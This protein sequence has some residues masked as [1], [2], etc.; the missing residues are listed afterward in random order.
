MTDDLLQ[1]SC[2][3][4]LAAYL[5]DLGKFAERSGAFDDD[6]RL[7]AHLTMYCPYREEQGRGWF[8]HRH[9]AHTA[10]AFDLLERHLPDLL[11][12][13]VSPFIG[14]VH[15]TDPGT[16]EPT[17]SLVNAAAAHH[18]PSTFLQWVIATADRIASGFEREEFEQYNL[19]KDETRDGL[20]NFT[21][22]QVTL[23]EQVRLAPDAKRPEALKWRYPLV[24]L[25]PRGI[26]P[27]AAT[28]CESRDRAAAKLEYR[29]LWD[30]F[31]RALEAIPRS[32]RGNFALW[33]D[34]FDSLWLTYTHAIPAATAFNIKP[35]VSLYD[36]S[37]TTAAL[38]VA[39]WRW[40]VA[41]GRTDA[42][43]TTA[44]RTRT[45]YSE[46]KFLLV[47]G[48][49]FGIQ[50]FVFAAGGE[51]RK[52]AAKLLRGRSF[53]VSLFTEI[54]AL[55]ILDELSLP[56]TSQVLNA[57]GK[58]LLVAPNTQ[59]VR[60]A[61][62]GVKAKFDRW[63]L[64]NSFGVAGLGLAWTPAACRDFLRGGQG[65]SS[66]YQDLMNRLAQSLEIA[67]YRRFGLATTGARIFETGY[68]LGV[69]EYNGRLPA[70]RPR[71]P[72]G[73]P[74]S[75]ALSRDQI[76]IGEALLRFDR[77]MVVDE[78]RDAAALRTD[79]RTEALESSYFG[80]R[81]AFT[82]SGE[83]SGAFGQL[84]STGA[85]R[86]CWDFAAADPKRGEGH[87]PLWSGYA[88]RF[89]SG[90][91]PQVDADDLG[92]LFGRYAGLE[93]DAKAP[94]GSVKPF[95]MLACEDRRP[96]PDGAGWLGVAALGV[97]KG[98]IDNLGNLFRVGLGSPTF[99]K[100]AAL[101]RQVNG[102]FAIY[103]PWLLGREFRSVYTVFAGGDDF[104]LVGPWRT[105]QRVAYRLREDF[106]RYVAGNQDV[107][108]SAGIASQKPG[109]PVS[110]LAELADAGLDQAK[111]SPGKDAVVCFGE[112]V[113]WSRWH[114]IEQALEHLDRLRRSENLSASFVYGLLHFVEMRRQ[115]KHGGRPDA[116]M[117][118]SRFAYRTRRLV[119]ERRKGS[120][121][122]ARRRL[123]AEIAG[124]ISATMERLDSAYRIALF[125]HL[126][127]FRSR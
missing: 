23:F 76:A 94:L 17:D 71:E 121:E 40:H 56:P 81:V 80:Y 37:R 22:R 32:H 72:G 11:S 96:E 45:D 97:L 90:Y 55:C 125:N 63:F 9:A 105:V 15:A 88:R 7:D 28:D 99:A 41:N 4:A 124:D 127:Q 78:G 104:F 89:I 25:S 77:I 62:E 65:K 14:R 38:A 113:P 111:G 114:E 70:D 101:S 66:P 36:H 21:A 107:H 109:A 87:E 43:A 74:A 35:E 84:A 39:I 1:K 67:K 92:P 117:W 30:G 8:T 93:E 53:Q 122:E 54:A 12:S 6:P 59:E 16:M 3:V 44:L 106:R 103:L 52:Q 108:F 33:L 5:H 47:Q 48:D 75:C 68:P 112:A 100:T 58:F 91:V 29:A 60:D 69:C 73:Q 57:A 116:A 126:Y 46:E 20:D 79:G 95:D 102:F 10:L 83:A 2:R 118:R 26:F 42:E 123:Q 64:D 13:D 27:A 49:F 110:A 120:D 98:D 31:V 50:D 85:L 19:S 24:P 18:K 86:R 61:L 51:T 34:H 82:Q 119:M 115:E